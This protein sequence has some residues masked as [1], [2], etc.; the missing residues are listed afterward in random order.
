MARP[1]KRHHVA[2]CAR[3][4]MDAAFD[5]REVLVELAIELRGEAVVVEDEVDLLGLF[6][7]TGVAA[8]TVGSPRLVSTRVI[9]AVVVA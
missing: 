4:D 5:Q 7:A 2:A 8:P 1:A 6:A 9:A 3:V